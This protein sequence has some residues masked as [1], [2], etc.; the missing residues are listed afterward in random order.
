M[1]HPQI[2]AFTAKADAFMAKYP[3]I[4]QYGKQRTKEEE[5]T[6]GAHA[7]P[8]WIRTGTW[9]HVGAAFLSLPWRVS[10]RLFARSFAS[11]FDWIANL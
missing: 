5:A 3:T 2:E 6:S 9:R 8:F 11:G 7:N 4:T 1:P 10:F